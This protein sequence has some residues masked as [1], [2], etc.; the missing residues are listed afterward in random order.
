MKVLDYL[1]RLP[2]GSIVANKRVLHL[3][4][5]IGF[6]S[7]YSQ[8][9]YLESQYVYFERDDEGVDYIHSECGPLINDG[10][11]GSR[12]N[13]FKDLDEMHESGYYTSLKDFEYKG[14]KFSFKY[15]DGCFRPYLQMVKAPDER[16]K[17]NPTM[18][19]W[20]TIV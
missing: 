17:V 7:D 4:K 15:L 5:R 18:S 2:E 1:K 14:Y 11:K 19:L 9:G 13:P 8:W 6:I 3:F 16:K 10:D 20:G 12:G